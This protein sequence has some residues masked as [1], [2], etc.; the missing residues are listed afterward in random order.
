MDGVGLGRLVADLP[1]IHPALF[2]Q[3]HGPGVVALQ[4]RDVAVD[5]QRLRPC[6]ARF[7]TGREGTVEPVPSLAEHTAAGP[8]EPER[9]GEAQADRRP[10]AEVEGRAQVGVLGTGALE[11]VGLTRPEPFPLALLGHGQVVIQVPP[12]QFVLFAERAQLFLPV[13]PQRLEQPESRPLTLSL[14][15]Q[16]RLVDQGGE[17]LQD[18]LTGKAVPRAN[19][20]GRAQVE[21]AGEDGHACP[22]A[23]LGRA[24]Q[25]ETPLDGRQEGLMPGQCA[26]G[27]GVGQAEA[28]VQTG[29]ELLQRQHPQA[30]GRQLDGQRDTRE[31]MAH[32]RDPR[33]IVAGDAEPRFDRARAFGE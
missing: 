5:P 24:A 12:A 1:G 25:R 20:L 29:R 32:P 21:S 2:Q 15:E 23:L 28:V 17:V 3:S 4:G 7:G 18:R 8:V 27:P 6:G 11:D 10:E 14:A 30:Y 19:T 31:Q 33:L 13:L 26:A 22:Q 16:H 9:R